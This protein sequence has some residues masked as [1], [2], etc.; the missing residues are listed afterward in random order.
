MKRVIVNIPTRFVEFENGSRIAESVIYNFMDIAYEAVDTI[1]KTGNWTNNGL[2]FN[3]HEQEFVTLL[4]S[5]NVIRLSPNHKYINGNPRS[6]PNDLVYWLDAGY[7]S[8]EKQ[9]N[10]YIN[11]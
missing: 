7:Y 3:S 2:E 4:L 1:G 10:K 8:F 11:Q 6:K 5:L 9:F